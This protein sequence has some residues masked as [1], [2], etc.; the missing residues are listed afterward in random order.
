MFL[1]LYIRSMITQKKSGFFLI[2]K[3]IITTKKYCC[4]LFKFDLKKNL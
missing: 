4:F 3:Q 1:F 2:I